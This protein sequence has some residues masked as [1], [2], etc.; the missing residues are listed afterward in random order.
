MSARV[1]D[2]GMHVLGESVCKCVIPKDTMRH[3]TSQDT[4]K[5]YQTMS[6]TVR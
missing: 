5:H 4:M 2:W 3:H 1:C 6:S